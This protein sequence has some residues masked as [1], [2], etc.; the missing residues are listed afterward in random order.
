MSG[1]RESHSFGG[2]PVPPAPV[3]FDHVA[4]RRRPGGAHFRGAGMRD[5]DLTYYRQRAEREKE[6][7]RQAHHPNAVRAHTMLAGYYAEMVEKGVVRPFRA[8]RQRLNLFSR[9]R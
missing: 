4:Q 5:D 9:T 8:S 6:L 7:A 1:R 2:E 3:R